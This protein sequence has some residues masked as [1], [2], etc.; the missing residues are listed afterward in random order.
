MSDI[1]PKKRAKLIE[2]TL[3]K[4]NC[5]I[6]SISLS[7]NEEISPLKKKHLSPYV[8]FKIL[9][10]IGQYGTLHWRFHEHSMRGY[11]YIYIQQ[12]LPCK[13]ASNASTSKCCLSWYDN[14]FYHML[15]LSNGSL[16]D[17]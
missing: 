16:Y 12:T 11:I 13:L 6:F 7:K 15:A 17:L 5:K 3:G 14:I 10:V 2:F 4:E 9:K 8:R 1:T